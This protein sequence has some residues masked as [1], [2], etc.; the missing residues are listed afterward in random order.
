MLK[1][2]RCVHILEMFIYMLTFKEYVSYVKK[3][4]R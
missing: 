4:G 2:L 3:K 1:P